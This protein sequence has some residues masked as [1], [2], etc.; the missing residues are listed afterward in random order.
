MANDPKKRGR[1][2]RAAKVKAKADEFRPVRLSLGIHL[3]ETRP[4]AAAIEGAPSGIPAIAGRTLTAQ[5]DGNDVSRTPI[6]I[7]SLQEF[8]AVF[9]AHAAP[10]P[11][12][13]TV[14]DAAGLF[15]GNGGYACWIVSTGPLS[16][17]ISAE[18][19]RVALLVLEACAEPDLL[20][21]PEVALLGREA[22]DVQLEALR[23][24]AEHGNRLFL[25]E[26]LEQLADDPSF[27]WRAGIDEFRQRFAG[28]PVEHARSGAA[29]TPRL[30]LADGR[31]VSP[32]AAVAGV[33]AAVDGSKGIWKAPAG[34]GLA[35]MAGLSRSIDDHTQG[36][37]NVD[38]AHGLSINA[39][40]DLPGLGITVWGARTLAGNDNEWRYVNVRRFATW[41]RRSVERG[42]G[43]AASAS[44]DAAAWS[45]ARKEVGTFVSELWRQGA[46]IGLKPDEAFFVH[47]GEGSTMTHADVKAGRLIVE[48]GLA[49]IKPREFLILRVEVQTR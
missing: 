39:I 36:G 12:T 30:I 25:A 10:A 38:P 8:E 47:A 4:N 35:A 28:I 6:R 14:H 31:R 33:I 24:C 18:D 27:D 37:L 1:A 15:F 26:P 7:Q 16:A 32:G 46:L 20:I 19:H 17:P 41:L 21:F 11:D 42:L 34:E 23:H 3:E 44:N 22:C 40:R 45:R 13:G 29:Y 2:I 43:W 49:P 9:G 48:I 5:Q